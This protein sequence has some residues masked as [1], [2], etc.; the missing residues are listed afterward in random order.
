MDNLKY[1]IYCGSPLP[2]GSA[3]CPKCGKVQEEKENLFKE[4]LWRHTKEKIRGDIDDSLFEIVKNWL[5]SHLFGVI[6]LLTVIGTVAYVFSNR[7]PVRSSYIEAGERPVAAA[8]ADT[9]TET[10]TGMDEAEVEAI[11]TAVYDAIDQYK[12]SVFYWTVEDDP[13]ASWGPGG[14]QK[15]IPERPEAYQLPA[16]YGTG[17]HEY[18]YDKGPEEWDYSIDP[19]SMVLNDP[20]TDLGKSLM[21]EGYTV[22][23]MIKHDMVSISNGDG[24]SY[25]GPG[26]YL[27]V[28]TEI[29]GVWYVAEDIVA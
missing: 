18:F 5:M 15:E 3:Q 19:D 20:S 11:R 28:L 10:D 24:T 27:F 26:E 14:Y 6:L 16:Q 17:R 2:E 9:G 22:A 7:P 12:E 23:E 29:D 1:C 25:A 8:Q 13:Y 4:Y 21:A